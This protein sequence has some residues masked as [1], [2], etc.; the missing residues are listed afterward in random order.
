MFYKRRPSFLALL[1]MC[2]GILLAACTNEQNI[3]SQK[4]LNEKEQS[5]STEEGQNEVKINQLLEYPDININANVD[6]GMENYIPMD[7][8]ELM[9]FYGYIFDLAEVLPDMKEVPG[10][11]GIY[12]WPGG[13]YYTVNSFQY[14]SEDEKQALSIAMEQGQLPITGFVEAYNHKLETSIVNGIEVVFAKYCKDEKEVMFA[15]F[16]YQNNGF[17]VTA[18][19]IT[20]DNFLDVVEYLTSR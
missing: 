2:L 6:P 14:L 17:F 16:L 15:Q 11:Y 10:E 20:E 18:E 19:G 5:Y 9:E 1:L 13:G 4:S 7:K 12:N 3:S 8:T